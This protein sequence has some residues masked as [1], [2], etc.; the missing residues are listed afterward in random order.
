M[1]EIFQKLIANDFSD[2]MGLTGGVSVPVSESLVNEIIQA[3][4]RGNKTIR[5]CRVALHEQNRASVHLKT[6]LLPWPLDLKLKLDGSMDFASFASP[7]IRAWLENNR[8]LGSL[9]AFFN[10]LPEGVKLYG[11]QV[12]I[13]LGSFLQTTE[14]KKLLNLIKAVDIRTEPGKV[15]FDITIEVD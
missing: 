1:D 15:I 8:L 3:A 2:L 6:T 12:V 11:S 9:A 14:Q 13:D 10:A 5:S 4:L 7:K